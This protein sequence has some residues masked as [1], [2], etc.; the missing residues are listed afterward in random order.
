MTGRTRIRRYLAR[1]A[2]LLSVLATSGALV[3]ATATVPASAAPL[4]LATTKVTL[5]RSHS[6]VVT[7]NAVDFSGVVTPHAQRAVTLQQKVRGKW[8]QLASAKSTRKGA[9]KFR[10]V[11]SAPGTLTFRVGVKASKSA[12]GTSSPK[13][14]VIGE[15]WHYL[16]DQQVVES[17]CS[18]DFGP[19]EINGKTY[20]HSVFDDDTNGDDNVDYNLK[21]GCV[22]LTAVAGIGDDASSDTSEEMDVLLDGTNKFSR[23]F[24][25]GQSASIN[26]KVS[27][28]LRLS[29]AWTYLAGGD[30]DI[31]WGNARILCK[32]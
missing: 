14:A 22:T 32:W 12:K 9:Y 11:I 2:S 3:A 17:N 8:K 30:D 15:R 28:N 25:L 29:L 10:W 21:R 6:P 16:A 13:V 18:C 20:A 4:K 19:D 23:D 24:A 27:G 7:G 31:G 26:L 1:S 5:A